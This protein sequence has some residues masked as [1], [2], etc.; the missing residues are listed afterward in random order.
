MGAH[1]AGT[2]VVGRDQELGQYA[3]AFYPA[4]EGQPSIL[5]ISGDPGMGKSTLLGEGA[6]QLDSEAYIGRCVHVGGDSIALAPVVD[7]IR[8]IQRP[9][10]GEQHEYGVFKVGATSDRAHEPALPAGLAPGT[11]HTSRRRRR[12]LW[13]SAQ[14]SGKFPTP[15][16]LGDP[17]IVLGGGSRLASVATS[18]RPPARL[19]PGRR[20][21]TC[22]AA[23]ES[24]RG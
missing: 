8:R 15:R 14:A 21:P 3:R 10:L 17:T 22:R 2:A 16:E 19:R 24:S 23:P 1:G 11:E 18:D 20:R 12:D 5:L 13:K 4:Q 6:R 9:G 7:L